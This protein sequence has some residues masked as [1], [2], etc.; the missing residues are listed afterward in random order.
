MKIGYLPVGIVCSLLGTVFFQS[1]IPDVSKSV[2]AF[3]TTMCGGT[4]SGDL[5]PQ[6]DGKFVTVLPGWGNYSYKISTASDSAQFYFDQGLNMYYSYHMKEALASFKEAARLDPTSPM[7]YWGQALTMGPYYNA[8]HSY[9]KPEGLDVALAAMNQ[10]MGNGTEKEKELIRAMNIRYDAS[11]GGSATKASDSAYAAQIRTL[12]VQ[13]A[14]DQDI[15]ALYID[16]VM[17]MHAWDFWDQ[18]GN[19]KPW[20][21]EVVKLSEAVLKENPNHPAVLHYHIHLTEASRNPEVALKNADALRV[22][23]P[24]VPHMVHMAS[25]EYQRN[26]RYADGVTVNTLADSNLTNYDKLA[27][28]LNLNK[29][30][31]H[32]FAVQTY[33]AFSGAMYEA[34]MKSANK[35]RKSVKPTAENPYDQYLFMMPV[36]T[37]VRMGKWEEILNDQTVLDEKWSYALILQHFAKGLASIYVGKNADAKRHFGELRSRMGDPNLKTRRIPFNST[38]QTAVIAEHILKGCLEF[39]LKNENKGLESFKIAIEAEDQLIYTEPNDWPLPARQVLGK[40][41][42][43]SKKYK[44]AEEIFNADLAINPGNGWSSLG[45]YHALIAQGKSDGLQAAKDH[46]TLAFAHADTKP[47]GP[48]W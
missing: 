32:Y 27:P 29:F 45:L 34:G 28:H 46:Y 41:F 2:Q 25:H 18:E 38:Y 35:C 20:T 26:S 1:E 33:C 13:Y 23:L 21:D 11:K 39:A 48:S 10:N 19:A 6:A 3:S 7:T 14:D 43:D 4:P 36:L 15:K 17:L 12:I 40:Y 24:G 47:T 22:L 9:M 5:L 37:Q 42:L 44:E 16:A 31:S 30:S 8:T